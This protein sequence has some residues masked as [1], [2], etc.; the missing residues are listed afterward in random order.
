MMLSSVMWQWFQSGL[1]DEDCG[2]SGE[3]CR[4]NVQN[5]PSV[6]DISRQGELMQFL[7]RC[8]SSLI[9]I[10]KVGKLAAK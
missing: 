5:V 7:N 2:T 9:A 8:F 6:G 3:S 1:A 10:A 4:F